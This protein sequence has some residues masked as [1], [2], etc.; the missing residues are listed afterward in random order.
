M[1][2]SINNKTTSSRAAAWREKQTLW[3]RARDENKAPQCAEALQRRR[4]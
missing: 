1:A 3:W 2:A 4:A